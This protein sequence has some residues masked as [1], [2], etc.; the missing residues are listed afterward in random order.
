MELEILEIET[1]EEII[2]K[3]NTRAIRIARSENARARRKRVKETR[4][5][6]T[7]NEWAKARRAKKS[8]KAA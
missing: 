3:D 2:S 6:R 4:E 7:L 1:S 8:R 5:A